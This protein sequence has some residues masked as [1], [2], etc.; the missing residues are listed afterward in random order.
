MSNTLELLPLS[1]HNLSTVI[2]CPPLIVKG[3][4][5]KN[6]QIMTVF[7]INSQLSLFAI[8]WQDMFSL[9]LESFTPVFCAETPEAES[10]N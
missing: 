4:P 6:R 10:V 5:R 7:T 1:K 3:F 2:V 8:Q 9:Y